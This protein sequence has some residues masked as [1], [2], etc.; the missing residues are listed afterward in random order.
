[1]NAAGRLTAIVCTLAVFGTAVAQQPMPVP[2]LS[3]EGRVKLAVRPPKV[4]AAKDA[5]ADPPAKNGRGEDKKPAWKAWQPTGPAHTLGMCLAI[6]QER[7]PTIVAAAASLAAA[8]RGYLALIG[9]RPIT[10]ILSPD[11]PVRK[12]QS[13]R[14]LAAGCAEVLKVRQENTSDICRLYFTY[15]Y[16]TQQEQ[17]AAEIVEQLDS[18]YEIARQFLKLG[19]DDPKAK[20]NEF[21]LG[22]I[23]AVIS[24]VRELREEASTGRKT[25]YYALKEAMGVPPEYELTLADKELPVMGGTIDQDTVVNLVVARR[26]ELVQSAVLVDVTR[27]EVSAQQKLSRRIRANTFASGTDL[28][29]R[30]IPVAVR[31][32]EYRP[33]AI[34]P[35]MPTEIVGSVE[36][37]VARMTQHLRV[38]EAA[39]E[40]AVGLV[41]LEAINA[42]LKWEQATRRVKDTFEAHERAQALVEK[43]RAAAQTKM[44]PELLVRTESLAS[45]A[46]ARYVTAVKDQI[47]ALV[48]LERVTAGGVVPL[49]TNR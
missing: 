16:A 31:N 25:A 46:Q 1:M 38:H 18:F 49:F 42:F 3:E 35:E 10:E 34:S 17:T 44:E 29:A 30:T 43:A 8:E 21:S 22:E 47:F 15:V 26:A 41:K 13:Q 11:L 27:L 24:E 40:K 19:L 48:A 23:D 4:E 6:G 7:Q 28:H 12:L 33:G 5:K 36:D 20:V 45:K 39:Y 37:R 32:G 9:L 14:G 2:T